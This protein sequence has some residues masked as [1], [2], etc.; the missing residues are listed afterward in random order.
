MKKRKKRTPKD[1]STQPPSSRK[2]GKTGKTSRARMLERADKHRG[3]RKSK[4]LMSPQGRRV[5][6]QLRGETWYQLMSQ[7]PDKVLRRLAA[8]LLMA[9]ALET[10][11]PRRF[12]T[13]T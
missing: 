5:C 9:S 1:V 7:A 2:A 10:V 8:S 11:R 6:W 13:V 12:S 4:I 3:S